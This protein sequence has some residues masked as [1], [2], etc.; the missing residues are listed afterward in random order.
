MILFTLITEADMQEKLYTVTDLSEVFDKSRQT[1]HTWIADGRFPN[2]VTVGGNKQV[3]VPASDVEAVKKEEA[4]KLM[5][6]LN[7]LGFQAATA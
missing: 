4:E 2:H 1:I 7:R 5:V 6:E 3:L